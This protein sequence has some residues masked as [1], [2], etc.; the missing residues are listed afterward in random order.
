MCIIMAKESGK[1]FN[2]EELVSAIKVAKIHNSHGAG[3]AFKRGNSPFIYL[4]KG[5]LYYYDLGGQI[6]WHMSRIATSK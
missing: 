2:R 4:S 6:S 5:Y 3:F 1:H